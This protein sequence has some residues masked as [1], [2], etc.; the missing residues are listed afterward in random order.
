[1]RYPSTIAKAA[2][3]GK[4][5]ED[6]LATKNN[7][8]DITALRNFFDAITKDDSETV[9]GLLDV[10][11]VRDASVSLILEDD[12]GSNER[13][14]AILHA[15]RSGAN[16]SIKVLAKHECNLDGDSVTIP[17]VEA[18]FLGK[19]DA[20]KTLAEVGANVNVCSKAHEGANACAMAALIDQRRHFAPLVPRL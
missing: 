7:V 9:E 1:M 14:K 13:V 5:E 18:T 16:K 3:T 20:V 12:D 4:R 11:S 15:V 8:S 19:I 10:K 6:I 2:V 17:I